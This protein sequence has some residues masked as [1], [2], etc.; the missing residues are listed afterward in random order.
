VKD[1][2]EVKRI[3]GLLA[4]SPGFYEKLSAHELASYRISIGNH[5]RLI[6][7]GTLE[8][9]KA[10][11]ETR[12]LEDVFIALTGGMEE[13]ELFAWRNHS[14]PSARVGLSLYRSRG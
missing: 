2:I 1:E 8:E 14:V 12:S 9:I 3:T 4:E 7:V 5:G 11:T 10:Q 13:R 6:A